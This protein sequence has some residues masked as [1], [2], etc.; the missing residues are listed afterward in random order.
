M[1]NLAAALFV[2]LMASCA[3][4]QAA[5]RGDKTPARNA[6]S[7][8]EGESAGA[9]QWGRLGFHG[10]VAENSGTAKVGLVAEPKR[11]KPSKCQSCKGGSAKRH[12]QLQR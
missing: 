12:R 4:A 1:R 9:A 11:A 8:V 5:D 3:A 2:G 10:W 6:A 7:P